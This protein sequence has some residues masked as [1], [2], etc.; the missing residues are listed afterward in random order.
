MGVVIVEGKGQFRGKCGASHC[1][2]REW[3]RALPKLPWGE[4]VF[5]YYT[6]RMWVM[7]ALP[8]SGRL[9]SKKVSKH[10]SYRSSMLMVTTY[11]LCETS[12]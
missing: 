7:D 3:R 9:L 5:R 6:T 8:L 12:Y 10:F 2:Q 1:N 4:L 11:L